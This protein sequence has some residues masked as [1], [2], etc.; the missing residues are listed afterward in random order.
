MYVI[1]DY[2]YEHEMYVSKYVST[3]YMRNIVFNKKL[4]N[5]STGLR[6]GVMYGR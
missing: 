6:F 1:F 5:I 3:N 2:V 4:Q